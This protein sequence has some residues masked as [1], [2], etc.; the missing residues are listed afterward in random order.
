[1]RIET[2]K[3]GGGGGGLMFQGWG[4]RLGRGRTCRRAERQWRLSW[5]QC[6]PPASVLP[7]PVLEADEAK[8]RGPGKPVRMLQSPSPAGASR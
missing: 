7:L 2:E 3:Q 4:L 6:P 1:M 5:R 8:L